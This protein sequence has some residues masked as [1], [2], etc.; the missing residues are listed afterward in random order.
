MAGTI[1]NG[2]VCTAA[3]ACVAPSSCCT[4][5]SL[6]KT[7]T[8][9]A[10]TL[11][12][13]KPGT[14]KDGTVTPPSGTIIAGWTSGVVYSTTACAAIAGSSSLVVSAIASFTALYTIY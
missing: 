14:A 7:G 12:C 11:L 5:V 2:A 4:G 10:T 1:A 3:T 6:T 9:V 8:A 13:W